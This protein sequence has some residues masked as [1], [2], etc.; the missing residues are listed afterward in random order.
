M[1]AVWLSQWLSGTADLWMSAS[2]R[3]L[4]TSRNYGKNDI[5]VFTSGSIILKMDDHRAGPLGSRKYEN[6]I[7]KTKLSVQCV[8]NALRICIYEFQIDFI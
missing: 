2:V 1:E 3:A 8:A 4:A 6:Q 7:D 5:S